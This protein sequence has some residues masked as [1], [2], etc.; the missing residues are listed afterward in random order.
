MRKIDLALSPKIIQKLEQ[1]EIE[2]IEFLI[3]HNPVLFELLQ[4][5]VETTPNWKQMLADQLSE[6]C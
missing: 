2:Q 6:I 5:L 4:T 1:F 3:E